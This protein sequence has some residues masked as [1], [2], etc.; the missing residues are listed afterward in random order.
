M[1]T[2]ENLEWSSLVT[3]VTA[4]TLTFEYK[5]EWLNLRAL[6][7]VTCSLLCSNGFNAKT[8]DSR[9]V[10]RF[11]GGAEFL[12][13]FYVFMSARKDNEVF[14]KY[15]MVRLLAKGEKNLS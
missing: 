11:P 15:L 10:I 1:L 5:R 14:L 4:L 8:R 9:I 7:S 6:P 3:R 12:H 2:S 13:N